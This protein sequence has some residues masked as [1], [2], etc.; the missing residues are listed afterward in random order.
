ML[1]TINFQISTLKY[2]RTY[3]TFLF[4]LSGFCSFAQVLSGVLSDEQNRP[5][6][7]ATIYISETKQGTTS[8]VDGQFHFK[9]PK[10]SYNLTIR[11]M[12]YLQVNK[13]INLKTDSLFLPITLQTQTFE[14]KEVKVFPGKEDPAYFIMRKAMAKA[15]FYRKKIKHYLAH[16]YIKSNFAFTNIPKLY[17]NK[18]ELDD[19][20]KLK[21][22]FKENVTYVIESHNKIT[23]D[24]PNTYDQ[25][26]ISKKT[27]MV[28]FDEPPVMG[29]ITTSIYEERPFQ[30][31]SPLSSMALKHYNFQYEGYI[32]V[33]DFDVFKIKVSPKRK[34]DELL[35]G[36]LY[37]VDKLWCVYNMDFISSFEFFNLRVKQQFQNLG[38]GNWL[39]VSYNITG[40][41]SMLGLRGTFYYGASVRYDSI[42]DNYRETIVQEILREKVEVKQQVE[43]KPGPKEQELTKAVETLHGKEELSNSDVRKISRLNRRILKEQY[44]DS[45]IVKEDHS[46]YRIDDKKDSL[47]NVEWDTIRAIPL[48]PAEVKSYH[49][50]DSVLKMETADIDSLTAEEKN[51]R[52]KSKWKKVAFGHS[53][54]LKD[55]TWRLGYEGLITTENFD[56]NAVD[57]YKYHQVLRTRYTFDNE[58][59]FY[60]TSK[61]GYAFNRKAVFWEM[62]PRLINAL[63]KN[64]RIGVHFGK[65][66]YDFKGTESGIK[67]PVNAIS[68]WFF[69]ENYMKL[70]ETGFARLNV[71]QRYKKNFTVFANANYDHFHPLENSISY[72]LAGT[73]EFSPN[74][75]GDYKKD[76][77]ALVEQKSFTYLLGINY[78]K[79]LRKPW[80]DESPFLFIDD[81]YSFDL[82]F[83]QGIPEVF[84]STSDFSQIDFSWHQQANISPSTGIDW[85]LNAGYF[86]N[87]RQLHFSQFKHFNTSEIP[88]SMKSFTNT[89]QTLN[90]YQFSSNKSYLNISADY[91]SEYLLLRYFSIVNKKTWSESFHI[92]YL[93]TPSIN[94][95]WE[96]GY[97]LN[98]LFFIGN[99]GIFS[100]FKGGD[101]EGISLK[102]SISSFD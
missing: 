64:N 57:G 72:P 100:G 76:D 9:L 71:S 54:F 34:S 18:I 92:N 83:K 87:A 70:Y 2:H 48:T 101:L 45:S 86:I 74:I 33:D 61:I 62:S 59:F 20:K 91:R 60:L 19:G 89:L 21:D 13:A 68:S 29:L 31:I 26:V 6:P 66:S 82:R 24:Y 4:V 50:A 93:S 41:V 99:I 52:R 3:L 46:R 12:G 67:P 35:D 25:K 73:K 40:D 8:N 75:P 97:S 17:Q 90:D 22:Y 14:I 16:L 27:S 78:R 80:L 38:A 1:T 23:Y 42:V 95:Y 28:G 36:Y 55:S 43:R 63:H 15:P 102:L 39:P 10:G 44:Q 37:I 81:F 96:V 49:M 7:Y 53:D 69:G 65:M 85:R 88:V 51:I 47:V 5:V 11:S 58:G 94:N 84:K 32:T 79:R 56:F 77:P 98:S 30:T